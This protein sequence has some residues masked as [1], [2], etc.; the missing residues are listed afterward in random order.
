MHQYQQNGKIHQHQQINK[1]HP[2]QQTI[3]FT[4]INT[5]NSCFSSQIIDHK[6]GQADF[7]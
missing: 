2:Y 4:N 1:I 3:K 6:K 7:A 5:T